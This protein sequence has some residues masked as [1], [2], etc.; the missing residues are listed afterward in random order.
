MSS[1]NWFHYFLLILVIVVSFAFA[2]VEEEPPASPARLL[3]HKN[4]QN[5]YLIENENIVI[6]YRVFNV[7]ER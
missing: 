7:G 3:V 6:D 5:K 4:V 1:Q 2:E